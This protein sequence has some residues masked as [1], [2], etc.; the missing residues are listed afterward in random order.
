MNGIDLIA[1]LPFIVTAVVV[2]VVMLTVAFYRGHR[3]V[4]ALSLFGVMLSFAA[5][6][7]AASVGP[8]RVTPLFMV[9]R[10]ALF[11]MG[12]I[13][14]AAISII[15]LSYGYLARRKRPQEEFYLLILLATLGT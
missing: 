8:R 13:F 5:L 1:L 6:G 15:L 3:I 2:T 4:A 10:Y 12:L 11:Y 7:P 14:A 9:D